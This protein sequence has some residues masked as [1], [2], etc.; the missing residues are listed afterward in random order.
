MIN[1]SRPISVFSFL[2]HQDFNY[3]NK[4][5]KAGYTQLKRG[6][7]LEDGSINPSVEVYHAADLYSKPYL[8]INDK[9]VKELMAFVKFRQIEEGDYGDFGNEDMKD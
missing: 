3:H 5:I 7:P 8:T 6:E 2:L 4:T 9:F 1:V